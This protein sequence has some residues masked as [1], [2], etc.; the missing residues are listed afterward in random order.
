MRVYLDNCCLNRPYDDQSHL[1]TELETK[2]KLKIQEMIVC[3]ELEFVASYILEYENND[4]PFNERKMAIADFIKYAFINLD[5][6][7]E[8]IEI[9]KEARGTGLKNK[10]FIAC[11]L[12][13]CCQLR[14]SS[15]NG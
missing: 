8:I 7:V 2:A 15:N 14:L 1:I 4:N 11:S 3:G 12:C 5:E 9:A 13:Y 6:T 10:R